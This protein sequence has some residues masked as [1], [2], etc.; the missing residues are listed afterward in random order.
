MQTQELNKKSKI[1][2]WLIQ[3]IFG[4]AVVIALGIY[5]YTLWGKQTDL[6]FGI[7][8]IG[9]VMAIAVG[10]HFFKAMRL[11]IILFGYKFSM[12]DF[13]YVYMKTALVNLLLPFKTGEIY[14]GYSL[15]QL[16]GSYW[17]GYMVA[18]FD[19]FMDT[20][21]LVTIVLGFAIGNRVQIAF[22]YMVL[23]LFLAIVIFLYCIWRSTYHFWNDF[24]IFKRK[25][26][27]T[28]QALKLLHLGNEAFE[29]FQGI[30]KGRF[31][32]TYILSVIAWLI[33]IYGQKTTDLEGYLS[34][35]LSGTF[36]EYNFRYIL[37]CFVLFL[38][39]S[40]IFSIIRT[41]KGKKHY[42]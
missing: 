23:L 29:R 39:G 38:A 27:R 40:L 28:I 15:R 4:A 1:V 8:E 2:Y 17:T 31:G 16:T 7:A 12:S 25:S 32:L 35:I 30:I 3:G 18:V 22:V 11:Y 36:N 26:K 21:A 19:R 5:I 9:R 13:L 6:G 33:E 42:E 14:R 24:L 10:V 34:S 20:I 37:F 41:G